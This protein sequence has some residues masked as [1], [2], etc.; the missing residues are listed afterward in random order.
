MAHAHNER[1]HRHGGNGS[2]RSLLLSFLLIFGFM[3]VE[4]VGGWLTNSL[5]LLSDAGH[6]LTDSGALALSLLAIKIG[7]RPPSLTKTFGY[8]RFEILAALFN[9]LALWAMVGIILH[10]AFLRL[11]APPE[12]NG[13]GMLAVAT[14]GL[15][16]NLVAIRLLH[17]HKEDNINIRGAFLHVLADSLGSVGAMAAGLIVLTTGWTLVD[18][19]ISLG[20][21]C[22]ILWSSWGIVRDAVHILLLGVPAHIDYRKVEQLIQEQDGVCCVYDLHIWTIASGQEAVTAHVVVPDG[23]GGQNEVLEEIGAGLARNFGIE[24]ATIQ[25]EESHKIKDQGICSSCRIDQRD[26]ACGRGEEGCDRK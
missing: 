1:S 15:I 10:E 11:Q 2:Q 26:R 3:L 18:P 16:V 9:G 17:S 8:R 6:M 19:L 23:F 25:I 22:L 14:V 4:A 13:R 24:H 21:C 7:Q 12:V 20:I 5:A